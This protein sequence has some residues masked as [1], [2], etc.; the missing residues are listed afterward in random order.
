MNSILTP[1]ASLGESWGSNSRSR[2]RVAWLPWLLACVLMVLAGCADNA[3]VLKGRVTQFQKE[4]DALVRQNQQLQS[5]I[6]AL[7]RSNQLKETEL[8]Q[9][10]QQ[11][12]VAEDNLVA[13]RGQLRDITS[14]L[15]QLKGEKQN[16]DEKARTLTASLA[17]QG[18]VS[19][20]PNN[21]FLQTLPAIHLPDVHV[22]RDG[23][24]IR[25]ELPGTR[26]FESG[27]PQLKPG[28]AN[29]VADVANEL[30]RNY[31]DQIVGIEG[32][33]DSDPV[34]GGQWRNNHQLSMAR[35]MTIYDVLVGSGRYRADQVFVVGHGSN[36]P[37]ASNATPEGKQRNRRVELVIYPE[38]RGQ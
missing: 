18:G 35:A 37:V 12:K 20:T 27:G 32:H 5:R 30:R 1:S 36:H 22:R 29:L 38:K 4:H 7:D 28:A 8:A 23:D 25:I 13:V 19:I 17:R 31:P 15:A 33:T 34:V 11:K 3:M 10:L 9:S 14:Q 16:S 2:P 6:D 24:V 21:S 26:L